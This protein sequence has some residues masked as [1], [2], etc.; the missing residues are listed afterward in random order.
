MLAMRYWNGI[1]L[2]AHTLADLSL[3]A[4]MK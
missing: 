1:D 2:K 4:V 3:E